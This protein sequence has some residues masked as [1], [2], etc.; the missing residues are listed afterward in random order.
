MYYKKQYEGA[1]HHRATRLF[2][3]RLL[4]PHVTSTMGRVFGRDGVSGME[5]AAACAPAS[6]GCERAR[7]RY[8]GVAGNLE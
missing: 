4:S 8:G 2:S 1:E 5:V 3:C 7:S 6:F